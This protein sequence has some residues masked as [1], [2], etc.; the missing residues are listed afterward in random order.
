MDRLNRPD[1]ILLVIAS[2]ILLLQSLLMSSKL[3]SSVLFGEADEDAF[4]KFNKANAFLECDQVIHRDIARG[5]GYRWN[6]SIVNI[7]MGHGLAS[8][9]TAC[10]KEAMLRK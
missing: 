10:K 6:K 7:G 1:I 9:I 5:G 8:S 3:P 4:P 2:I